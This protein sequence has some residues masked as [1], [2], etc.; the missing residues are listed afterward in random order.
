MAQQWEKIPD[1]NQMFYKSL[2][3]NEIFL[4]LGDP[5]KHPHSF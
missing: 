2:S 4:L 3:L 1:F 5:L